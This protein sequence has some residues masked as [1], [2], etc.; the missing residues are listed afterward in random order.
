MPPALAA[1]A[2]AAASSAGG[3][4]ASGLGSLGTSLGLGGGAGAAGGVGSSLGAG[5]GGAGMSGSIGSGL[6]SAMSGLSSTATAAG[7]PGAGTIGA[8]AIPSAG[9][10]GTTLGGA[11]L[12][13]IGGATIPAAQAGAGGAGMSGLKAG[14]AGMGDKA[15]AAAAKPGIWQTMFGDLKDSVTN[16]PR[17]LKQGA[18][19]FAKDPYGTS[20]EFLTSDKGQAMMGSMLTP[21]P[22]IPTEPA[23]L[24]PLANRAG[25]MGRQVNNDPSG[26]V[27][28]ILQQLFGN[29]GVG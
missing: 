8:G 9:L 7:I 25:G 20:K 24:S 14:V 13:G 4:I 15:A 12:P 10:T 18:Q 28:A 1:A 17:D 21:P 16:L 6:S 5:L 29:L 3:A 11:G 23:S 2:A 19:D 27:A 22:L 26:Q